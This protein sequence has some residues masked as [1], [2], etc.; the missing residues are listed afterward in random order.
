MDNT[1]MDMFS[2]RRLAKFHHDE[3]II[4]DFMDYVLSSGEVYIKDELTYDEWEKMF[5]DMRSKEVF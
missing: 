1:L 4:D 3:D 2:W 5:A